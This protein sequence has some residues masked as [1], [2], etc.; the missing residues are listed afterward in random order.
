MSVSSKQS[1]L[2]FRRYC[3]FYYGWTLNLVGRFLSVIAPGR[4]PKCPYSVGN[5]NSFIVTL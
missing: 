5:T 3:P 2:P 1:N 4:T